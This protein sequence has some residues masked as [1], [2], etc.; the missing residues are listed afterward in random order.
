MGKTNQKINSSLQVMILITLALLL[1]ACGSQNP[2]QGFNGV[3]STS[4]SSVSQSSVNTN[5]G[6]TAIT[7]G[8]KAF[9]TP[10]AAQGFIGRSQL[11]NA[12]GSFYENTLQAQIDILP[13]QF[14]DSESLLQ[15]SR[16]SLGNNQLSEVSFYLEDRTSQSPVSGLMKAISATEMN[17]LAQQY[18]GQS[19][20]ATQFITRVNFV[21]ISV[22]SSNSH[23]V[24]ISYLQ[25]QTLQAEADFLASTFAAD[26]NEFESSFPALAHLHPSKQSATNSIN[27][28]RTFCF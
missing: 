26:I 27:A 8:P 2:V 21:L 7:Q 16:W 6:S 18:Y 25:N 20:T 9:C 11:F 4:L 17:A 19:L 24:R 10:I 12:N 15:F 13:S 1:T 28:F 3:S 22:S 23:G 5:T 14:A